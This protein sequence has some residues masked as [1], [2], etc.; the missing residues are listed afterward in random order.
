MLPFLTYT[1]PWAARNALRVPATTLL[2]ERPRTAPR[3]LSRRRA[4]CSRGAPSTA[5]EA[6]R[7]TTPP[8]PRSTTSTPTIA[9]S[10]SASTSGATGDEEFLPAHGVDICCR[11]RPAV[12]R[13]SASG[14]TKSRRTVPHPRRHRPGRVHDRRQRQPVHE[15]H[16]ALQPAPRGAGRVGAAARRPDRL[17]RRWSRNWADARTRPPS[18]A[19]CAQGMSIPYDEFLGIHPQD[20]H[21]LEREMWDLENTPARQAPAAAELPP[22][23]DLPASRC[24]SR[25]TCVLALF[26]QG[27]EFTRRAEEGA[28][29]TTTTRSPPATP[30]CPPCVQSIVAAE[31]GYHDARAATTS[32]TRS[33]STSTT[34]T[35]T[36]PTA[37]T[38]PRPAASGARSVSGFGGFRDIGSGAG[39][40]QWQ[41][42]PRLPGRLVSRST[43]RVTLHGT[44][45]RVTVR[46]EELELFVE[47]GSGPVTIW[48]CAASR[49]KVAAGA[50]GDRPARAPGTAADRRAAVPGRDPS[51][52]TGR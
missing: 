41:V 47:D 33:S 34:A 30:R 43:Y 21:F 6:S 24:S 38:S 22:A 48:P 46:P 36:P 17:R 31:V 2:D 27:E 37:C 9:L 45:V 52:P 10:R 14:A 49:S 23:G 42:D 19:E 8:A 29:S 11:D 35:T 1:T 51:G 13:P 7:P 44:R 32:R 50:P 15:R 20:A 39:D 16:G 4:P 12:G 5:Q 40:E 28:T 25:P 3:E 18:W 26:L